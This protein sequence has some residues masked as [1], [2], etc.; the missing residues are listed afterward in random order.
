MRVKFKCPKCGLLC[1]PVY[2]RHLREENKR[3]N[4]ALPYRYCE[5]CKDLFYV[6]EIPIKYEYRKLIFQ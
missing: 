5:Q 4:R 1:V 3:G 2:Y 6:N